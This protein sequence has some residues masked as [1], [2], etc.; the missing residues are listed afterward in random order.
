MEPRTPLTNP[1]ARAAL[2]SAH[3]KVNMGRQSQQRISNTKRAFVL[4]S[5][6]SG[7]KPKK[8]DQKTLQGGLAFQ[9]ARDCKIC[10]AQS[11]RR[12]NP[13]HP[14]PKRPHHE[15]CFR[16]TTTRG[17]PVSE[18][19]LATRMESKKLERLFNTPLEAHE[20]G[21]FK[22]LTKEASIAFFAPTTK[23]TT[24]S[25]TTTPTTETRQSMCGRRGTG[26]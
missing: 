11:I 8:G 1:Y 7:K 13:Q 9:A 10:V 5:S 3:N 6:N 21:S 26:K 25:K 18:Q 17:N 2:H 23:K 4:A 24:F 19:T 14:V 16:N 15:L 20:K 22:Y 12:F